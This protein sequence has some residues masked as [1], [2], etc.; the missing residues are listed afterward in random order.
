MGGGKLEDVTLSLSSVW[1]QRKVATKNLES[2]IIEDFGRNMPPH[3]VLHWD[4]KVI[5]YE[6][7][8]T[9]DKPK[10]FFAAP[11][12]N[13]PDGAIMAETLIDVLD[14]WEFFKENVIGICWDITASNTGKNKG[15]ATLFES[16][17]GKALLWLDITSENA[18]EAVSRSTTGPEDH[19]FKQFKKSFDLIPKDNLIHWPMPRYRFFD[20]IAISVRD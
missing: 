12:I 14:S 8:V 13:P 6:K 10:Q 19:L 5:V 9:D 17:L 2:S 20:Q 11:S 16:S 7:E 18:D 3:I 15:A 4:G 1:R